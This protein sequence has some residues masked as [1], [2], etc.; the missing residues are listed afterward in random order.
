MIAARAVALF[1]VIALVLSCGTATDAPIAADNTPTNTP[2][3]KPDPKPDPKPDDKPD[4]KPDAEPDPALPELPKPEITED[5]H[6]YA[7]TFERGE[8]SAT[9]SQQNGM[10][11]VDV[12]MRLPYSAGDAGRSRGSSLDLILS[13]DGLHGRHLLYYP[14]PL[15]E[16]AGGA[17]AGYRVEIGFAKD[18]QPTRLDGEPTFAGKATYSD[19]DNWQATVWVDLRRLLVPGN[20]PASPA[21]NWFFGLVMG[22]EAATVV[23]PAGLEAQNPAKTSDRL[24]GFEFKKLPEREELEYNPRDAELEAEAEMHEHQEY[25]TAKMTVGDLPG[26][27]ERLLEVKKQHPGALWAGF[28]AF[29]IS[30]VASE[31]DIEGITTDFLPLQKAY[32]EAGRGQSSAHLQYLE[33]LL[34]ARRFDDAKKH[35][36]AVLASPLSTGRPL[37]GDNMR[38]HWAKTCMTNGYPKEAE[39]QLELLAS[40]A[41]ESTDDNFRIEYRFNHAQAAQRVGDSAKAIKLYEDILEKEA[42]L[43]NPRQVAQIQQMLQFQRQAVEQWADEL[44]YQ[45]EDAEKKNPRWIIETEYGRIVVELFEDDAPNTVK[46]LV[47]LAKDEFYDDLNFHRVIDDFMAQGGCPK[48]TG[49]GSPGWRLKGELS[50]RNHFRGTVA[51]ARTNDPD[52]QGSQFYIC[53]SNGPNVINLSGSYVVVGRVI[54]GMEHADLLKPGSKIKSIR[55]ENLRDHEYEPET[56]PE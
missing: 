49:E 43:L 55:A 32:V 6:V 47:K 13:V 4:S 48:G 37:T 52:S 39:A 44:K 45:A 26:A 46:A 18:Q 24:L 5:G 7:I 42:K 1:G 36:D 53:T 29:R 27:F 34:R 20:S 28:L 8:G 9:L 56:L 41:A 35:A 3:Q 14:D 10:L 31:R 2:N 15:W 19:W 30:Q 21:E 50:R 38:M 25:I 33:N 12:D 16:P 51:M 11:R 40:R 23:F 54:E 17:L 22:N